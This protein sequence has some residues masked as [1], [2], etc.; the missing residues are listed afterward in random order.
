[1]MLT[2]LLKAIVISDLVYATT[3]NVKNVEQGHTV[4]FKNTVPFGNDSDTTTSFTFQRKS[5]TEPDKT[6]SLSKDL[7]M[8]IRM[9][10]VFRPDTIQVKVLLSIDE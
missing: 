8:I 10:M 3:A 1:M 9:L 7:G 6:K 2:R 5:A 4:E